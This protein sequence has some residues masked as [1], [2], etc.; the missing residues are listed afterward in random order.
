MV[1][2]PLPLQSNAGHTSS[3]A[4]PSSMVTPSSNPSMVTLPSLAQSPVHAAFAAR[5]FRDEG[6]DE[7]RRRVGDGVGVAVG[8][9]DRA[10]V[11]VRLGVLLGVALGVGVKAPVGEGVGVSPQPQH[12]GLPGW[13]D[14]HAA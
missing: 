6:A 4:L 5:C 1:T 10:P 7:Q 2:T 9:A 12:T 13:L 11:A 3:V 8:V 14:A